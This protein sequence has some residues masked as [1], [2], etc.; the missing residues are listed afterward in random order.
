MY[1]TKLLEKL[2]KIKSF[3]ISTFFALFLLSPAYLHGYFYNLQEWTNGRQTL[4]LFSDIHVDTA[5]AYPQRIDLIKAAK[6]LN[7]FVIVEDRMTPMLAINLDTRVSRCVEKVKECKLILRE[8]AL[9][10]FIAELVKDFYQKINRDTMKV[11]FTYNPNKNYSNLLPENY[12]I[13]ANQHFSPLLGLTQFCYQQGIPV[14]NVEFRFHEILLDILE[15]HGTAIAEL[16][17]YNDGQVLRKFYGEIQSNRFNL[18]F[19]RKLNA[20]ISRNRYLRYRDFLEYESLYENELDQLY[21]EACHVDLPH[22][23]LEPISDEERKNYITSIY[24]QHLID[25]RILH[26]IHSNPQYTNIFVCAG[27]DHIDGIV[28][29]L[30]MLGFR[31]IPDKNF[32][33]SG[34]EEFETTT[35]CVIGIKDYFVAFHNVLF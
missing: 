14:R 22:Y 27:G 8:S 26:E 18:S 17:G 1:L 20:L 9:K 6:L 33:T 2:F 3:K 29:I 28:E 32:G 5:G 7:A 34:Q 24:N 13:L 16:I 11:S 25:A 19:T 4:F 10:S 35:P 12:L 31:L 15:S 23:S 30:P 21:K